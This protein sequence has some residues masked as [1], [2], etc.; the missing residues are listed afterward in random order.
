[1]ASIQGGGGF[2]SC[3]AHRHADRRPAEGT[4]ARALGVLHV[5]WMSAAAGLVTLALIVASSRMLDA[6]PPWIVVAFGPPLMGVAMTA[7][8]MLLVG[9]MGAD[10]PDAAREW[11]AAIGARFA[12]LLA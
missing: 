12:M 8:V 1:M 3:F 7:G 2:I 6:Q 5:L 11:T 9:L 4:L 10:Y